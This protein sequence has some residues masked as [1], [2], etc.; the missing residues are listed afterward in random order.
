MTGGRDFV[1]ALVIIIGLPIKITR[2][3]FGF[4]SKPNLSEYSSMADKSRLSF[5]V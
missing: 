2:H 5:A 3:L 4:I 1:T